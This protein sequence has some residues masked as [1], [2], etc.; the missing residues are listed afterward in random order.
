[1]IHDAERTV[2][3]AARLDPG[4]QYVMGK[5]DIEGLDLNGEAEMRRIWTIKRG[6][7]FDLD[8]PAQFLDRVRREGLFDNLGKTTPATKIDEKT[9]TAD[10]TLTF[11]APPVTHLP[12][13]LP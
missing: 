5:L 2:D 4:P 1:V 8:Y 6:A 9:Q 12:Q 13:H 7:P 10:V 3:V 11:A